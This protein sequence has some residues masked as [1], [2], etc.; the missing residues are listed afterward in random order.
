MISPI[1]LVAFS[2]FLASS[3]LSLFFSS[4]DLCNLSFSDFLDFAFLSASRNLLSAA[5][6][7]SSCFN[8]SSS[9]FRL[10][11]SSL[12]LIAANLSA[13]TFFSAASNLA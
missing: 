3:G 11:S 6:L 7:S 12:F 10:A 1:Q 13:S 5:F 9:A 2:S 8:L 4:F